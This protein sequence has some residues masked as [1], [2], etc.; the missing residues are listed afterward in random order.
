MVQTE[1]TRPQIPKP[2]LSLSDAEEATALAAISTLPELLQHHARVRPCRPAV[3]FA[4]AQ[5][6]YVELTAEGDHLGKKL[7]EL[8]LQ[9]GARVGLLARNCA[10]YFE[11]LAAC[12]A[13]R[14]V[15][16]PVNWR[17]AQEEIAF[18]LKDADIKV[19][20]VSSDYLDVATRLM[21]D[22][23]RSDRL[24]LLDGAPPAP[25]TAYDDW[26]K[27]EADAVKSQ[28]LS[29]ALADDV[30]LQIYSSGTTGVP[31]GVE[32]THANL[33]ATAKQS[34]HGLV[35][36]WSANDR[37][38][39]PLPLFHAGAL[40]TASYAL[41]VGATNIVLKD[42]EVEGLIG[43]TERHKATKIGLVPALMQMIMDTPG[44]R[45]DR[46]ASLDTIVYGG[47]AISS[48]LL[49]RALATFDAGLVQL[50]GSSETFTAGTVLSPQ[51][52][53]DPLRVS[54]CGQPMHGIAIKV[55]RPDGIDADQDEPGEVL[56]RSA[57]VMKGYW[58]RPDQ[59]ADVLRDGWYHT[60]DV[61]SLDVRGMLTIRDRL[62]DMIISGGENIYPLEIE[63]AL[64]EH[65]RIADCAVIG[66]PDDRWGETVMAVVVAAPGHGLTSDE[67]ITHLRGRIAG[68]KCP[69]V[70]AFVDVLPRNAS[71][72]VLKRILRETYRSAAAPT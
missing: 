18:I 45:R 28:P 47:S 7:L 22:L 1:T 56:I 37:L 54:T 60:G 43:A 24:I 35:G 72:K 20:F 66:V 41:L 70:V 58:G 34:L 63:N 53:L 14:V 23:G 61:G 51:D 69:R 27:S 26:R 12:G 59:S 5:Q 49:R 68:Y 4:G 9:A 21:A 31:K 57:T 65:P 50:F 39:I 40:L 8:G 6:T 17:L 42:A 2:R 15:L 10:A 52:H 71:G 30:L 36:E 44:F 67:V 29:P 13:A 25:A 38:L 11:L 62:R 64:S 55:I 16:T 33:L 48:D 3:V 19:L 46:L 32:L